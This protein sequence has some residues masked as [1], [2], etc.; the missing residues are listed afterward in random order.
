MLRMKRSGSWNPITWRCVAAFLTVTAVGAN[1]APRVV[2]EAPEEDLGVSLHTVALEHVFT[3]RNE[4]SSPLEVKVTKLSCGCTGAVLSAEEVT[5]GAV[6]TCRI[7]Y[8]PVK[9]RK[10]LGQQTF[11]AVLATNDPEHK[12]LF[13]ALKVRLVEP[14]DAQPERLRFGEIAGSHESVRATLNLDCYRGSTVPRI[15]GVEGKDPGLVVKFASREEDKHRVRYVYD[16]FLDPAQAGGA[17]RSSILVR[18]GVAGLPL[19]EVPVEATI[20]YPVKA[21]PQNVLLGLVEYGTT[22]QKLVTLTIP[23]GVGQPVDAV[24]PDFRLKTRLEKDQAAGKWRL[25]VE[26]SS[27]GKAP[28][29][30]TKIETEVRISDESGKVLGVVPVR[31]VLRAGQ[32]SVQ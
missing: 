13:F 17:F 30:T 21:Q 11:Q 26:W 3:F 32:P 28:S 24:S 19:L 2:V 18:T 5:P 22:V 15:F 6:G 12:E 10:R 14:V 31:G 8:R 9:N 29:T 23:E 1:A 16:V 7:I 20:G 4:G 25:A 27:D